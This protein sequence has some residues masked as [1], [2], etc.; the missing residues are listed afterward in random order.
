M[1]ILFFT[2]LLTWLYGFLIGSK[3]S[4]AEQ[5]LQAKI[6]NRIRQMRTPRKKRKVLMREQ[7]I[8]RKEYNRRQYERLKAAGIRR[9]KD[10][11]L[12]RE[13][14]LKYRSRAIPQ[15]LKA[16]ILNSYQRI[17]TNYHFRPVTTIKL[18][19]Y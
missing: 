2:L 8:E 19:L 14:K 4:P 5:T 12:R 15:V 9:W 6:R 16:F 11:E 7:K 1:F 10:D 3:V 13:E 17:L 18:Q